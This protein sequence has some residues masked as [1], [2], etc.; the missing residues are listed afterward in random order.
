MTKHYKHSQIQ[1]KVNLRT[2]AKTSKPKPAQTH[3]ILSFFM[4]RLKP[5]TDV[6]SNLQ[7]THRKGLPHVIYCRLW[8]WPELQSH[9]ELR[10]LDHCE[11][12]FTAKRDEVCINPYHYNRIESPALPAILVPR[13]TLTN[14]ESNLFP[15][16]LEDLSTSVPENT[17]FPHNT[18]IGG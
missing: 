12:A 6:G 5:I 11:Y 14:D 9:H 10:P 13:H 7:Q 17:S 16:S 4:S 18:N 2:D 1:G 3:H 15:H 8:R